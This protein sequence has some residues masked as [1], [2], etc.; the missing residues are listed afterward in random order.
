MS[1][2]KLTNNAPTQARPLTERPAWKA[3]V[4]HCEAIRGLHLRQLFAEDP[5]RGERMSV[6]G[7][8]Y[9]GIDTHALS[10][11]SSIPRWRRPRSGR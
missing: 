5:G 10:Q 3:L 8:L 4:A 11:P 1:S 6:D 7:P 9:L 2:A